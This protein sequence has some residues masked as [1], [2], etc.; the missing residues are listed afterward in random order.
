MVLAWAWSGYWSNHPT[1]VYWPIDRNTGEVS[2]AKYYKKLSDMP[3]PLGW[4]FRYVMPNDLLGPGPPL[5]VGAPPPPPA[6]SRV[7]PW[8]MAA[9]L[10]LILLAI[11][12]V[13][14]LLQRFAV[15]FSLR[16]L[17]I[18]VTLFALYYS[19]PRLVG[20]LTGIRAWGWYRPTVY[21]SPIPTALLVKTLGISELNWPLI[22]AR[23]K[24]RQRSFE[25]FDDP[26]DTLAAA[27]RLERRGDWSAAMGMYRD[28][29][30]KW[31]DQAAYAER[32]QAELAEK[33]SAAG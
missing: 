23:F 18:A 28:I 30:E 11:F 5:P 3:F 15:K 2:D 27:A 6:P 10:L 20:E 16:T 22:L 4:P 29:A 33:Q 7:Y 26:E 9:N 31:P 13:V 19:L 21:F 32:C 25:D 17:L 12:C 8:A 24:R 14:Y 1:F